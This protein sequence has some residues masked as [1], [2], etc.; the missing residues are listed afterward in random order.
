MEKR[1]GEWLKEKEAGVE[2]WEKEW[3]RERGRR[4]G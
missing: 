3:V 1:E 4:G 2:K